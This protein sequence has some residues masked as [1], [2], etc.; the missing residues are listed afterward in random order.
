MRQV[1]TRSVWLSQSPKFMFLQTLDAHY[2]FKEWQ[3]KLT[4]LFRW[5]GRYV[6]ID[7]DAGPKSGNTWP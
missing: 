4:D 3:V 6:S 2:N 5:Q 1:A 7:K